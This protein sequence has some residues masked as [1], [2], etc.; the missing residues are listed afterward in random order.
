MNGS[1]EV[2]CIGD[3]GGRWRFG[4]G[5]SNLSE[6]RNQSV[7]CDPKHPGSRGEH[8]SS[9]LRPAL[10]GY[11]PEDTCSPLSPHMSLHLVD[12]MIKMSQPPSTEAYEESRA[13]MQMQVPWDKIGKKRFLPGL[14]EA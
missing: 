12:S 10:R 14:T 13:S 5:A 3:V 2:Q 11:S 8:V 4:V 9:G 1:I 7:S 6:A